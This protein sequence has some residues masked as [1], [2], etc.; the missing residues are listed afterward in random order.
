[1]ADL[2]TQ[3]C[4][5][6][7]R[8]SHPGNIGSAA[9]AMR[10]MGLTDQRLVTPTSFPDP[11]ADTL[12]SGATDVLEQAAVH[13]RLA[14][15]LSGCHL[16]MGL[17]ARR[18][19][20]SLP[21]WTPREAAAHAHAAAANG[22]GVGVLF[23]NESSGL[24]NAELGHCHAMVRIPG[25]PDYSSL[26]LAQAV[27][28]MAYELRVTGLEAA[29]DATVTDAAAETDP[30]ADA[31]QMDQFFQHLDA[32]LDTVEFAKGSPSRRVMLRLRRFFQRARP[33]ERELQILHG[34]LAEA[35]RAAGTVRR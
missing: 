14:P 34:I 2:L 13:E 25:A 29:T 30:P 27:Q 4:F 7:V 23:G 33:D 1:M 35:E 18:R 28:V 21:E 10:T 12:A 31:A 19:G 24:S 26:N 11:R 15:A 3:T 8:T 9:R 32:M 22:E 16:V 17:S 20:V 5:V 6:L